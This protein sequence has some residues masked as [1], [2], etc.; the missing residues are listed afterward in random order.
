MEYFKFASKFD[1]HSS[2]FGFYVVRNLKQ[3]VLNNEKIN[4]NCCRFWI[5]NS[6]L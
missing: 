2:S 3:Q 1:Q 6:V 5:D 4:N